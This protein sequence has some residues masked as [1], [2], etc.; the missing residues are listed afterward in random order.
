MWGK[1]YENLEPI[2]I[3]KSGEILQFFTAIKDGENV[4]VFPVN[5][6][7]FPSATSYI[8]AS[9]RQGIDPTNGR[10][11]DYIRSSTRDEVAAYVLQWKQEKGVEIA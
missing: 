8:V 5:H 1:K 6:Q 11:Y 9:L 4:A 7:D 3:G 2:H 10:G